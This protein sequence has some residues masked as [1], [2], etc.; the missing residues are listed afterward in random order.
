[1]I[2]KGGGR[3][4]GIAGDTNTSASRTIYFEH[5]PSATMRTLSTHGRRRLILLPPPLK[6]RAGLLTQGTTQMLVRFHEAVPDHGCRGS[7]ITRSTMVKL[8]PTVRAKAEMAFAT[9]A[10]DRRD[11]GVSICLVSNMACSRLH[12]HLDVLFA[13]GACVKKRIVVCNLVREISRE[14]VDLYVATRPSPLCDIVC[15]KL[16]TCQSGCSSLHNEPPKQ[17]TKPSLS[18]YNNNIMFILLLSLN[19][20]ERT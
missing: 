4:K 20:R 13:L 1:M 9:S 17:A 16:T 18:I 3:A 7:F 14:S 6:I 19:T 8:F 11:V 15:K 5:R 2:V 10:L 12:W